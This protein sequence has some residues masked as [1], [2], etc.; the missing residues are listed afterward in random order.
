MGTSVYMKGQAYEMGHLWFGINVNETHS[1]R[2]RVMIV[3]F[4]ALLHSIQ[5]LF[6]IGSNSM[7]DCQ[8]LKVLLKQVFNCSNP[9]MDRPGSAPLPSG[10][11]LF[12]ISFAKIAYLT[13]VLNSAFFS[14][15]LFS[16]CC[17]DGF[18]HIISIQIW[19][20]C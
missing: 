15:A 12:R 7:E 11:H 8:Y 4:A 14:G 18:W 13:S 6:H 5:A 3:A 2:I 10:V 1:R 16:Q 20:R 9:I 17:S 19:Q